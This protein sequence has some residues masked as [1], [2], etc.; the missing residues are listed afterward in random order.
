MPEPDWLIDGWFPLASLVMIYGTP[1]S[2]KSFVVF[3]QACHIAS[4]LK[5]CGLPT[6]NGLVCYIAAEDIGG[7]IY[8]QRA[9]SAINGELSEEHMR[10]Y[11]APLNLLHTRA[12]DS[13]VDWALKAKPRFVVVDTLRRSTPGANEND[14]Q[15]M[16]T[17]LDAADR[18][19][20]VS[21][22]TVALVHH[23][24]KSGGG[25]RGS[26]SLGGDTDTILRLTATGMRVKMTQEKQKNA[27]RD[28]MELRM[29]VV[30]LGT[31]SRGRPISSLVPQP[32][33]GATVAD[34]AKEEIATRDAVLEAVRAHD[35]ESSAA[36]IKAVGENVVKRS[37]GYQLLSELERSG[38]ISSEDGT[39]KTKLWFAND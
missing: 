38:A 7:Y 32:S 17:A 19:R 30:D 6:L 31:D 20:Q 37:R 39:N 15:A 25:Y 27:A 4:G 21:G 13:A 34:L 24:D 26:S 35:G 10:Y 14:T 18:I 36:I 5:W 1:G 29:Q 28:D 22:A 33:Q 8:R 9:W 3:D 11:P 23:A 2:F 16:G 12:V